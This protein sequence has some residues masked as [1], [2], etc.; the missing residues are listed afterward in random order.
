M[1]RG[2]VS[3]IVDKLEAKGWIAIRSGTIGR[4]RPKR[5][6]R[7]AGGDSS[8]YGQNW[9]LRMTSDSFVA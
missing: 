8:R 2:A 5:S 6:L 4:S 3:K 7:K 9:R 1:T